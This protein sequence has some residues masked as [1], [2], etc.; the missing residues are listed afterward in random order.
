L[1]D[2]EIEISALSP[3]RKVAGPEEIVIGRHGV[4]LRKGRHSA[5]YLPLVAPAQGW[6]LEET[7]SHLARKAGLPA[8]GWREGATFEVFTTTRYQAPYPADSPRVA[9]DVARETLEEVRR[10]MGL[11]YT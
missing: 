8:D 4:L 10:V 2:I 7:L 1:A 9:R 5:V 6:G 11:G 3:M